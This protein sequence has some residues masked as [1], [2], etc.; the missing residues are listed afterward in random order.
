MNNEIETTSEDKYGA[1]VYAL[2]N[3]RITVKQT[4]KSVAKKA[5][6]FVIDED[7]ERQVDL[8]D[9]IAIADAIRAALAGKLPL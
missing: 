6:E 7:R 4:I 1:R 5:G 9:D 8:N 2:A 3:G